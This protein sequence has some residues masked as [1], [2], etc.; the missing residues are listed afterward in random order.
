MQE[1]LA[2]IENLKLNYSTATAVQDVSFE[3]RKG[4]ILAIIGPN[5]SGKTSVIECVEGLRSPTSG[6]V[7]VFGKNPYL[8]R[9]SIYKKI[10]VQLQDTQYPEKIKVGEVCR[11]FSSFYD[12]PADWKE[13]ARQLGLWEK[14]KRTV[15][16]LSGGEKQRLSILLALLP[17]PELLILD[18]LTTGLDPEIRR[19]MW[20]SLLHIKKLGTTILLVSHYIN[21]VEYLA[22]RLVYFNEGRSLFEGSQEQFREY[23]QQNTPKALWQENLTLEEVYLL[24]SPQTDVLE[25]EGIL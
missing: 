13:L 2:K 12:H 1:V 9:H 24:L 16:K 20:D 7:T 6:V 21:E 19:G 3:V 5:G 17:R 15:K 11:L 8:H 14:Q 25:L 22:D 10:G 18:E 23:V 4:E